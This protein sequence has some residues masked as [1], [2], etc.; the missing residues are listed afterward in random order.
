[1]AKCE[2]CGNKISETFLNKVIGTYIK[3]AKGKKH[4]IC[5][6]CQAKFPTKDEIMKNLK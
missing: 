6:E 1:M 4:L 5:F 2:I 3:D